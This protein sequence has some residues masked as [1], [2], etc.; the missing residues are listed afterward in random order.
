M[1]LVND[2]VMWGMKNCKASNEY[3]L[4]SYLTEWEREMASIVLLGNWLKTFT[5]HS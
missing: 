2:A 4:N 1:V 3:K 5:S